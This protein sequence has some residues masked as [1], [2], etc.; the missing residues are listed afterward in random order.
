MPSL[1][2]RPLFFSLVQTSQLCISPTSMCRDVLCRLV[3]HTSIAFVF[4]ST[5]SLMR[6]GSS[7]EIRKSCSFLVAFCDIK[8]PHLRRDLRGV[9]D[10]VFHCHPE[11]YEI[12]HDPRPSRWHYR[13]SGARVG[14]LACSDVLS[15]WFCFARLFVV[16]SL[17]HVTCVPHWRL[18]VD[19]F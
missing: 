18:S 16:V 1:V 5:S 10:G 4:T 2:V 7:R 3:T 9:R 12:C 8:V 19:L 17:V 15:T 6:L 11:G 13:F 14:A